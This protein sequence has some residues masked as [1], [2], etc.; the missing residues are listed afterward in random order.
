M[1][2]IRL[3][4]NCRAERSWIA[5]V[6]LRDFLGLSYEISFGERKSVQICAGGQTLDVADAFFEKASQH[7]LSSE[8]LPTRR[9]PQWFVSE[10]GLSPQLVRRDVPVIFGEVGFVKSDSRNAGLKLDIFGSAFFML[11]RYEEAVRFDRDDHDRFPASAALAERERFLDRPIVDEYVEILWSA[12]VQLWPTL[13]RKRHTARVLVS[14]DVDSPFD[15]A[16]ESL[17]RLGKRLIGQTW[18]D[19]SPA[20]MGATINNYVKVRGGDYSYDPYRSAIDWIM[21]INE[22]AGNQVA[23]FF[24][25][26]QTDP[27]M[28]NSAHLDQPRMRGLLRT[29][30]YRGHEI[31]IHPGYNTYQHPVAFKQ[32]VDALRRAMDQESIVQESM[33]GR[34]HYLRWD[35]MTTPQLWDANGLQYDSTLSYADRPGFRCGTCREYRMYSLA[36]RQP[37]ALKQRPLLVMEGS[38]IDA[39]YMGLGYSEE[40][41][42]LMQRYKKICKQYQGD[43]TLLWHNSTLQNAAAKHMCCEIV[44]W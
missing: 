8:S 16:C 35:A 11:S 28:D 10:S 40:A 7:W 37:L 14:C 9:L 15:P 29:I 5:S 27:R 39:M 43:F 12:I 32:S 42:A 18:R 23:F 25:P 4:D 31:G 6:I 33:G 3:P 22:Q 2:V 24:I 41:L 38:V 20:H 17:P 21:D 36:D 30:H 26:E 19:K 1:F 44:K 34:Q 13:V